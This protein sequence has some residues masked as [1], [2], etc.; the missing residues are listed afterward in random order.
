MLC[1]ICATWEELLPPFPWILHVPFP[2]DSLC[3]WS[4]GQIDVCDPP[5]RD[6]GMLW[7]TRGLGERLKLPP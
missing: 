5:A 6:L 1:F 3:L 7:G 4:G 2:A